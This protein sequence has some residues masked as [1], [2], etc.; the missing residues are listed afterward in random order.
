MTTDALKKANRLQKLNPRAWIGY[1]VGYNSTN[2]YRIWNPVLNKVIVTRDVDFNEHEMF[3]GDLEALKDDIRE[4]DLDELSQ[5]L[6]ECAIPEA[7]PEEETPV[8][9]VQEEIDEIRDLEEDEIQVHPEL[10]EQSGTDH[11]H[12]KEPYTE[13]RF[14]PYPTPSPSPPAS[15][16][17]ASIRSVQSEVLPSQEPAG[18]V[19]QD[20]WKAVFLA[21]SQAGAVGK[22]NNKVI[23]KA[24]FER[25]LK[26]PQALHQRDLPPLPKRHSDLQEHPMGHLFEEAELEH[27]KSHELMRSW[28][29]ISSRDPRIK[30]NKV[31]D[32]KWVYV[33]KTDKHNRFIKTKAQL[34]V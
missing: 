22:V 15:L 19:L 17:A 20:S 9:P 25:L 6:Q 1:L 8:Q 4:L 26:K 32:C 31:L 29:E 28:L 27:L 21:G 2:V 7:D 34:V 30:G 18:V 12:Y 10:N 5:L 14:E 3:N 24:Q 13:A 16:L 33:Y 11:E 23:N